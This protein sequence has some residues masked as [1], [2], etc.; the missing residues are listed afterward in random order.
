MTEHHPLSRRQ[1]LRTASAG[2]AGAG[3]APMF[4]PSSAFGANDRVNVA[5]IGFRSRGG[6]HVRTESPLVRV[7]L[8]Q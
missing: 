6:A 1:F 5:V 4:I 7:I 2:I 3:V 8:G